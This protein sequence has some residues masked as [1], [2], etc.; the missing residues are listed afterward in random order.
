[1]RRWIIVFGLVGWG[2]IVGLSW[3]LADARISICRRADTY[4]AEANC[5]VRA[6]AVRDDLLTFGLTVALVGILAIAIVAVTRRHGGRPEFHRARF[7]SNRSGH[8]RTSDGA[9][10]IAIESYRPTQPAGSLN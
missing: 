9:E 1:M 4:T 3:Y 6:T 10:A 7:P 8:H 5:M 2:G